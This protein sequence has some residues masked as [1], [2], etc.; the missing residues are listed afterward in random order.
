[1]K[2]L[3]LSILMATGAALAFP[4]QAQDAPTLR[5]LNAPIRQCPPATVR[6]SVTWSWTDNWHGDPAL[7]WATSPIPAGV[8]ALKANDFTRAEEIFAKSLSVQQE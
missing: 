6:S 4:A 7:L 3:T 8:A 5:S 1:M 2:T